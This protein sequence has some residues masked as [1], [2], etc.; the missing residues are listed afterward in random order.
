[1]PEGLPDAVRL[2]LP[3]HLAFVRPFRKMLEG[4]LAAQGWSE[5]SVEDA[6][7]VATEVVQNAIEHGSRNDGTETVEASVRIEPDAVLLEVK[8]PG[9][10][11][12]PRT[13]LARNVTV[14]PDLEAARGRGL[15]L[16]HRLSAGFDRAL[17]AGGGC[18]IRVR[19]AWEGEAEGEGQGVG[20]EDGA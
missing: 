8:D 13:F 15:F 6:A 11:K 14:P 3:T 16:I 1:M 2:R 7:L 17:H 9:T 12:D 10:G 19:M 20:E 4:L 18:L 5:E